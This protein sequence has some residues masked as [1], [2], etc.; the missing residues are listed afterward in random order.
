MTHSILLTIKVDDYADVEEIKQRICDYDEDGWVTMLSLR[1]TPKSEIYPDVQTAGKMPPFIVFPEEKEKDEDD[2]KYHIIVE[3]GSHCAYYDTQESFMMW[4]SW[5]L[6]LQE[7]E[8]YG[9][10]FTYGIGTD[11]EDGKLN[12]KQ[13]LKEI[14][15]ESEELK[16][17]IK[18][19]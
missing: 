11:G 3:S 10:D 6:I 19:N 9:I 18:I 2:G 12:L 4:V 1:Q 17:Y 7:I 8:S 13:A 14:V 16:K 5:F 15:K